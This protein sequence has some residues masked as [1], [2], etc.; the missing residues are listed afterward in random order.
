MKIECFRD[1]APVASLVALALVADATVLPDECTLG[2]G[3][4]V[5]YD[6]MDTMKLS[7]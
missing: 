2:I 4:G 7:G 5:E 3:K 6:A 1:A